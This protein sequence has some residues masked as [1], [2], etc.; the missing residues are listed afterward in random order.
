MYCP[1][2]GTELIKGALYC[3][4]CGA[5]VE[6]MGENPE[7]NAYGGSTGQKDSFIQPEGRPQEERSDKSKL[8]AGLL[9]IF[10]GGIGV[11][12]FYLG[13]TGKAVAQLVLFFCCAGVVSSIWGFIEGVLIL[14]GNIN[15]DAQGKT[16]RE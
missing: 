9:G 16:L 3:T 4:N 11:H 1:Y 5:K 12:N 8:A 2:C 15:R 14:A 6:S 7:Q 13:Y 10:L